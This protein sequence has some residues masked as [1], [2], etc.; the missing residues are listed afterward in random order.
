MLLTNGR[1]VRPKRIIPVLGIGG[2]EIFPSEVGLQI[3][4]TTRLPRDADVGPSR[5]VIFNCERGERVHLEGGRHLLPPATR[6]ARGGAGVTNPRQLP[7]AARRGEGLANLPIP[8]T[9][10]GSGSHRKR[11][12]ATPTPMKTNKKKKQ[13]IS[14]SSDEDEDYYVPNSKFFRKIRI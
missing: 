11:R 5:E 12:K 4:K 3:K 14:L 1:I 2:N 10:S 7:P 8:R 6:A 13:K 9:G